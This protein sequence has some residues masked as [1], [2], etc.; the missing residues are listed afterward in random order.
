MEPSADTNLTF[1]FLKLSVTSIMWNCER[2]E[3]H[4][5]TCWCLENKFIHLYQGTS[6]SSAVNTKSISSY[7]L[8]AQH[9]LRGYRMNVKAR[10]EFAPERSPSPQDF[11]FLQGSLWKFKISQQGLG[12]LLPVDIDAIL[13]IQEPQ[14]SI[15]MTSV[16][17]LRLDLASSS[18]SLTLYICYET[19][20]TTDN[21][22][23]VKYIQ[24]IYS[25]CRNQS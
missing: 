4:Y 5:A 9:V 25:V 2:S 3:Q 22:G 6:V 18:W 11:S 8:I 12:S 14:A 16:T 7:C 17:A 20:N 23:L 21:H 13:S 15:S 19:W 1:S 24:L 10:C